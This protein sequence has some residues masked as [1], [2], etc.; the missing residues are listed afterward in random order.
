MVVEHNAAKLSR[1]IPS[2]MLVGGKGGKGGGAAGAAGEMGSALTAEKVNLTVVSED[3]AYRYSK[4]LFIMFVVR[5]QEL[6]VIEERGTMYLPPIR[7]DFIFPNLELKHGAV[8]VNVPPRY[9]PLFVNLHEGKVTT[10]HGDE[11]HAPPKPYS[12]GIINTGHMVEV[13][14]MAEWEVQGRAA[15]P[16]RKA[17]KAA[18]TTSPQVF[19]CHVR[20]I[21][22]NPAC[23]GPFGCLH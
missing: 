8:D 16:R 11:S 2:S 15:K 3:M 13:F 19:K 1:I 12:Q 22:L 5:G 18:L 6:R 4:K 14:K 21:M 10:T 9:L 23:W 7:W 20:T 17:R